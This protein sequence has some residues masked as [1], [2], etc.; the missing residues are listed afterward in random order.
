MVNSDNTGLKPQF[1]EVRLDWL[2]WA[3]PSPVPPSSRACGAPTLPH[4]AFRRRPPAVFGHDHPPG[5]AGPSHEASVCTGSYGVGPTGHPGCAD[6]S[7]FEIIRS[8]KSL[9]GAQG[10]NNDYEASMH[11]SRI[12]SR[13][14]ENEYHSWLVGRR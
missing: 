2:R 1:L 12:V 3:T 5:P 10:K 13:R 9:R 11:V 14:D 6:I 7:T 4:T 8:D